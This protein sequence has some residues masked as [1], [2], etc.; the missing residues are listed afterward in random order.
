MGAALAIK[1]NLDAIAELIAKSSGTDDQLALTLADLQN[2][3]SCILENTF[4]KGLLITETWF[5]LQAVS[6]RLYYC[7]VC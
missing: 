5:L 7:R 1:V 6:T 3:S 2:T 4:L